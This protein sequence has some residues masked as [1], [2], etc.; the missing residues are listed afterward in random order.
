MTVQQRASGIWHNWPVNVLAGITTS[1]VIIPDSLAFS[2][3]AGVNPSVGIYTSVII[4]FLIT[5]FGARAGM[6]SAAAGS[7]AVLMTSLVADHGTAYLFSATILTGAIQV[8]FGFLGVGKW[9]NFVS[10]AVVTGFINALAIFIFTAQLN[11]F[12]GQPWGLYAMVVATL[13]IVFL[14]PRIN[15]TIPSPL[16]A[17]AVMTLLTWA[18]HLPLKRVEDIAQIS[19]I[20]PDFLIPHVP[21][22]WKTVQILLPA[23]F[24]LAIVGSTETML[25]QDLLDEMMNEKTDKN[26]EIKGQGIANIVTGFFGGM[27]GCALVAESVLNVKMGGK[28]R[29]STLTSAVFLLALVLVFGKV[30]SFIPM[31]ALTGVMIMI[32]VKIFDW[33]SFRSIRI[34][35]KSESF[36]MFMTMGVAL[37][38]HNLAFGVFAGVLLQVAMFVYHVSRVTITSEENGTELVYK[39]MGHLFFGSAP[40]LR[41]RI[42]IPNPGV[43][44]K[45]DLS[46]AQIW[47]HHAEQIIES[48]LDKF[49]RQGREVILIKPESGRSQTQS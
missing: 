26:R 2:F 36:V 29:L 33:R 45:I 6:A 11:N 22:T 40:V 9:M 48:I 39:V 15:R 16:V 25:T 42:E 13:G 14:F 23:A 21:L 7:T 44:V 49:E 5:F 18:F 10:R 35:P 34:I 38:T 4:M 8:A 3:I 43:R 31:A 1:L 19:S 32:C 17:V 27:A 12:Q 20:L 47:D 37:A 24:S 28:S 30:L 41:D 46:R